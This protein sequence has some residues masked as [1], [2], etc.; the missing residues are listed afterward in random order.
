MDL[1]FHPELVSDYGNVYRYAFFG[2][3][4][5]FGEEVTAVAKGSRLFAKKGYRE[6]IELLS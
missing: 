5:D 3:V 1:H 2:N 6:R 4:P